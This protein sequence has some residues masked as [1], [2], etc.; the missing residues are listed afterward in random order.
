MKIWKILQCR[1][2]ARLFLKKSCS[3]LMHRRCLGQ[4]ELLTRSF[5]TSSNLC[6]NREKLED[7]SSFQTEKMIQELD[8]MPT[9]LKLST[10]DEYRVPMKPFLKEVFSGRFNSIVLSY[11]DVLNNDRYFHVEQ[12]VVAIR[13]VLTDRLDLVQNIDVEKRISKDILLALRSQGIFGHRGR[14]EEGGGGYCVTESLRMI[15]EVAT[16]NL[17]LSSVIVNSAWY[18]CEVIRRYGTEAAQKEL[19]PRLHSG[20]ALAALCVVDSDAGVDAKAT[21]VNASYDPVDGKFIFPAAMKRPS[22]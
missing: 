2:M 7:G 18:G 21:S 5:V 6:R 20:D 14:I 4:T 10:I 3:S 22:S 11:P 1:E 19:L 15:E 13:K 16:A 9:E 17:S 8:E 12:K